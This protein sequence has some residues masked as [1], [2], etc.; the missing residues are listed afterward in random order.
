MDEKRYMEAIDRTMNEELT[1]K[2]K[3]SMLALGLAGEMGEV[4]DMIKKAVYHGH[5]MDIDELTKE[6]GDIEWYRNHLM[7]HFNINPE[8]VRINNVMKL[9]KRYKNGFSEKDS[10]NREE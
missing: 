2:E 6:L 8:I 5:P 4:V 7:K 10:I 3:L 9:Q 1:E